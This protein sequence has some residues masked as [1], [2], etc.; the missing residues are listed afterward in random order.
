MS[1]AIIEPG[2]ITRPIN[3]AVSRAWWRTGQIAG[4]SART[5]SDMA[6]ADPL[7]S[8][9]AHARQ[10]YVTECLA[11]HIALADA[12]GDARWASFRDGYLYG[13]QMVDA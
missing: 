13:W 1:D 3:R 6:G 4:R 2:H 10:A 12:L 7:L 11:R 5:F 8:V 9:D